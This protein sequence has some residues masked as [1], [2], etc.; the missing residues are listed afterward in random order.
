[1][2]FKWSSLLFIVALPHI[3]SSTWDLQ[4]SSPFFIQVAPFVVECVVAH[5][6]WDMVRYNTAWNAESLSAVWRV[7]DVLKAFDGKLWEG[8]WWLLTSLFTILKS[9]IQEVFDLWPW[10]CRISVWDISRC[11]AHRNVDRLS[12]VWRVSYILKAF[13]VIVLKESGRTTIR[14]KN[15]ELEGQ[16]FQGI[17]EGAA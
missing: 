17:F 13:M 14:P 2:D 3:C 9:L 10:V 1:M 11:S 15:K 6:S 8:E 16:P 7:P 4:Y 5:I 12:A